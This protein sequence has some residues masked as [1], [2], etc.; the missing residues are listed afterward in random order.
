MQESRNGQEARFQEVARAWIEALDE[1]WLFVGTGSSL[2]KFRRAAL[3]PDWGR[4]FSS[5]TGNRR[6]ARDIDRRGS[7]AD[8]DP[9]SV[10]ELDWPR[11]DR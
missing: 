9:D 10:S 3:P 4:T 7:A 11:R 1:E 2:G 5:A 8:V 6:L